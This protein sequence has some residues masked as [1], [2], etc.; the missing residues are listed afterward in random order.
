MGVFQSGNE[1]CT[2]LSICNNL[3]SLKADSL[4]I[5]EEQKRQAEILER[6]DK[7]FDLCIPNEYP[8]NCAGSSKSKLVIRVPGHSG[9]PFEVAC[10]QES[11]GGGW[12]V[13]MRRNDGSQ[14]FFL[15]W[16]DYQ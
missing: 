5:R 7:K 11:H 13:L 10:D 1:V 12:T 4:A 16:K 9:D 3:A 14:D 15:E 8:E 6:L 2:L